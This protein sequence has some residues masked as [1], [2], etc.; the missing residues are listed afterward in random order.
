MSISREGMKKHWALIE[1]YRDGEEIQVK[2]QCSNTWKS[3]SY[4][5]FSASREYRVKPKGLEYVKPGQRVYHRNHIGIF[6]PY[7]VTESSGRFRLFHTTTGAKY[8]ATVQD[9]CNDSVE[10]RRLIKA[11]G[12]LITVKE[13]KKEHEGEHFSGLPF[14]KQFAGPF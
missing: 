2:S 3:V 1:T 4:P 12:Y 5:S 6:G 8:G 9:T 14:H 11:S 10:A 13:F 7:L